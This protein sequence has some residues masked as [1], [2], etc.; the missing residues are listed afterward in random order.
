M[1]VSDQIIDEP[2]VLADLAGAA[3]IGNP[4]R[5]HDRRIVTHIVDDANEAAI[6]HR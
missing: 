5:L 3:A 4:R 6:E 2:P 1:A